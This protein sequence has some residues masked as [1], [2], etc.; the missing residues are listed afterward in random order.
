M[1]KVAYL[2]RGLAPRKQQMVAKR[3]RLTSNS[4]LNF[5]QMKLPK[6]PAPPRSSAAAVQQ[7]AS[8]K[9]ICSLTCLLLT[10]AI[11]LAAALAFVNER[12]KAEDRLALR[13][14]TELSKEVSVFYR[15]IRLGIADLLLLRQLAA[16]AIAE[17]STDQATLDEIAEDAADIASNRGY[18]DQIRL[19]SLTGMERLR[20]NLTSPVSGPGQIATVRRVPASELQDKLD[21]GWFRAALGIDPLL[22]S[23]SPLDLNVERGEIERPLKPTIRLLTRLPGAANFADSI[24]VINFLPGPSLSRLRER[25]LGGETIRP[26]I[27]DG[28][29]NWIVGPTLRVGLGSHP[30]RSSG[31][32]HLRLFPLSRDGARGPVD[33]PHSIAGRS[34]HRRANRTR[35]YSIPPA[36]PPA[37][38]GRQ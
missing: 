11:S 25:E 7:R 31:S 16:S 15:E 35:S 3:A 18:Y 5:L 19:L 30:P 28:S 38:Q 21:R 23:A 29:G 26:M 4:R 22:I 27:A 32:L 1:I 6:Q 17:S 9:L 37:G 34:F 8:S 13:L 10:A 14:R 24:L 12:Q 20:V 36:Q 33:H 2:R